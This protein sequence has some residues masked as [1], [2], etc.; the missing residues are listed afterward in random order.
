MAGRVRGR[1]PFLNWLVYKEAGGGYERRHRYFDQVV[2]TL[3]RLIA[4]QRFLRHSELVIE[5]SNSLEI[6]RRIN[7]FSHPRIILFDRG[8]FSI[9]QLKS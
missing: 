2:E 3:D 7:A 6:E 4:S 8:K 5:Q 1:S 9:D